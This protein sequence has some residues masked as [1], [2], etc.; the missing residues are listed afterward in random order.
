MLHSNKAQNRFH[1]ADTFSLSRKT[2]SRMSKTSKELCFITFVE[3]P[4]RFRNKSKSPFVDAGTVW[5]D[6]L[7]TVA[8]VHCDKANAEIIRAE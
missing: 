2:H 3:C 1:K 4:F 6:D 7:P 8:V 5:D